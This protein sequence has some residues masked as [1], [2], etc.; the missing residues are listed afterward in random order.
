MLI[1]A[2]ALNLQP[3]TFN[4]QQMYHKILHKTDYTYQ[5]PVSLCHN[6]IRLIPR[7]T[8]KQF[9]KRSVVT[10]SPEPEVLVEYEDFYGNKLVYFTIEKEH[11][12]LSVHVLSEI[13]KLAPAKERLPKNDLVS[14]EEVCR[15]THTLTPELLDV[16]Q[17][18]AATQMTM[19]DEAIAAYAKESFPAGMSLFQGAKN[20]MTRI[21]TDFK[22]QSGFTT[23]STPLSVVMRE[24]KGVCQDF[25]HLAIACLRS[26]GLPARYVSGY[27]ET[28]PPP[29][30]VKLIGVDASHAW[31]SVYL[32]D[33]GWV[34]FDPTNNMIPSE[35]HI[36]IGWGRDYADITPLRGVIMS[37]GSHDLQVSVDVKR[38]WE[39]IQDRES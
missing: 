18:I 6:I 1:G 24:R 7:S 25:A 26:L 20:L 11:K 31:F 35:R 12:K 2:I 22:F 17:F 19:A 27:I 29:G 8:N 16:K 34:D 9:C 4:H 10:I 33:S 21:F 23:I 28:I 32:P 39:G 30:V 15:L 36:T 5:V 38:V 37:S 14:W 13:E 3:S